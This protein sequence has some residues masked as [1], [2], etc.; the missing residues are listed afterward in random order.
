MSGGPGLESPVVPQLDS[1]ILGKCLHGSIFQVSVLSVGD[2]EGPTSQG[3]AC[4]NLHRALS[5]VA[6]T[7]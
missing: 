4:A 3:T 1:T 6:G 5:T 7:Q 2:N